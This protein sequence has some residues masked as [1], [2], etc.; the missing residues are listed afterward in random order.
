MRRYRAVTSSTTSFGSGSADAC[1]TLASWARSASADFS[2]AAMAGL[3]PTVANALTRL[4]IS[5]SSAFRRARAP[6]FSR[7][8]SR[9]RCCNKA[10][11]DDCSSASAALSS[12][13][14]RSSSTRRLSSRAR[15]IVSEL[16][17]TVL[18]RSR[19]LLQP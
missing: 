17:Q 12:S 10:C 15:E 11:T 6:A 7:E 1:T 19:W 9:L 16:L 5:C 8:L 4:P 14:S 3:M 2:L 18:P 13:S